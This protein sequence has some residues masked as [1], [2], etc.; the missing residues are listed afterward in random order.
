M[1]GRLLGKVLALP[2]RVV[3]AP[4]RAVMKLADAEDAVPDPL[5]EVADTIERTTREL[6]DDD[7]DA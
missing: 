6:I 7:E 4:V 5:G 2:V 1:F 3:N